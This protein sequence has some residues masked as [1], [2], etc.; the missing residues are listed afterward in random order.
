MMMG[1]RVLRLDGDG[2]LESG[3]RFVKAFVFKQDDAQIVVGL[4]IVR[5]ERN[6]SL[7]RVPVLR[8]ACLVPSGRR[9]GCC[10]PSG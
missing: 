9:R 6:G 10:T 5:I 2:L 7:V 4:G 8:P 3:D 1:F